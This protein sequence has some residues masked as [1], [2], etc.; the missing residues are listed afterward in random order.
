MLATN[1]LLLKLSVYD[2]LRKDIALPMHNE[3]YEELLE[4]IGK[5]PVIDTHE[6]L[7][8]EDSRINRKIDLFSVFLIQYAS[9]DLVSAGMSSENINFLKSESEDID[10]KWSIFQPY[11]EKSKNTTYCKALVYAVK[12]IY[13]IDDINENTYQSIDTAMKAANM[14]GLY[15]HVLKDLCKIEKSI[16][17][18]DVNCDSEFFISTC[19]IGDYVRFYSKDW[20]TRLEKQYNVSINSLDDYMKLIRKTIEDLKSSGKIICLKSTLA[21]MRIIR[22]D[23]TG[24]VEASKIFSQIL[25]AKYYHNGY[26][27]NSVDY[28]TKPLEDHIMHSIVQIAA[29]LDLPIQIH[30]GLQEGNGNYITNSNPVNLTNLFLEYPKARF[31]IF[32][33]GYPYAGEL[34]T[35]AK[36][37]SN[38]YV[39]LC[40][41]HIISREYTVRVIEELLD[42]VPANKI[43]GFGGDYCFVE[44]VCGH[45]K[46][47]KENIARALSNKIDKG[48]LSKEEGLRIAKMMLYDNAKEFF[49]V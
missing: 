4:E 31:D 48:Y 1:K 25:T 8:R 45:L 3:L 43:F 24:Y 28:P 21:Y 15:K 16:L 10:N 27:F 41:A 7:E 32:H 47:A 49:R 26:S 14:K 29:E 20:I 44:G 19:N 46:I 38:V 35:L 22:Y 33:A 5:M 12:D 30:T 34:C 40:W 37:F 13:G 42:T 17:D 18:C 6:H 23:R 11:W 2:S 9:C 39:D 36:N